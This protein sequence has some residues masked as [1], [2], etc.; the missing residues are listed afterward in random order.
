M[1][2]LIVNLRPTI[3]L[4]D[5][6]F[7]QLCQ[8]NPEL[9][10]ERTATGELVIMSPTGSGTGKRNADLTTDVNI[11]NRQT[12][13]GVVFDSSSGFKLPNGADRSPDV[14]WILNDRW[15]ALTPEQQERFA[16]IAPDFVVELR[17]KT[18][19]LEMLEAKMQE[20]LENG[21]RLGWLLDPQ[22][23]QAK[24]YRPGR[25]V[26]I[27]LSPTTL[28]GEDVLPGFALNLQSIFSE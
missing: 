9:R 21:V 10:F 3:D 19:S 18:D 12:K 2:A 13:L 1:T 11:W 8:H 4:T 20:Y 16:P 15:N 22:T 6:Q 25:S 17:S 28:S 23:P 26:E 14:T 24:I 7:F 5:E 27:I